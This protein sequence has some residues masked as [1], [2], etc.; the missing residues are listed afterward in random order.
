MSYLGEPLD[1]MGTL[2]RQLHRALEGSGSP[3][4]SARRAFSPPLDIARTAAGLVVTLEVPGLEREEIEVALKGDVLTVTGERPAVEPPAGAQ[5]L[6]RERRSGRFERSLALPPGA[7]RE[8][9]A[10][11]RDGVLTL[12]V[13]QGTAAT[14]VPV[15]GEGR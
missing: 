5:L 11:L 15:Q 13:T 14:R 10:V 1:M 12:T 4:E 7:D 3:A 9:Q 8:V 6:R 2:R